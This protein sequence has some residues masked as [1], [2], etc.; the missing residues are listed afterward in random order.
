MDRFE[1]EFRLLVN[2]DQCTGYMTIIK[3]LIPD[4]DTYN[5]PLLSNLVVSHIEKYKNW[6][7][8]ICNFLKLEALPEKNTSYS[9]K[10]AQK[11][12]EHVLRRPCHERRIVL[13]ELD[14][15]C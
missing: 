2:L 14:R 15:P 7:Q 10:H 12:E 4:P 11:E 9:Y 1:A 3:E 13:L 6:Q 8:S 5:H